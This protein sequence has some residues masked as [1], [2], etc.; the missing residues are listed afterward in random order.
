[1]I[2]KG[3]TGLTLGLIACA[4]AF[5][6]W[7]QGVLTGFEHAA[8]QWRVAHF[9]K[10]AA[11][12]S[13]LRIIALDQKSL[14][15]GR[16]ENNLSWP[17]PREAYA[18]LLAF[19]K[20][21]GVR[22]VAFDMLFSE[23]S[24]H[25]VGDDQALALAM[26]ENG[27]VVLSCTLAPPGQGQAENGSAPSVLTISGFSQWLAGSRA[28]VL[29]QAATMPV[30][31]LAESAAMLA[32]ISNRPDPDGV[33]RRA[34][35][36]VT[37]A[38]QPVPSLALAAYLAGLPGPVPLS[39]GK[40]H[41]QVGELG[42]PLDETGQSIL[43]FR[44]SSGTVTT[45]S[46]AAVVQSELQ[47][48]AGETPV[49]DPAE[50]KDTYVFLGMTAPGLYDL[51]AIPID[52]VYPGVE[53]HA[54][55]LDNLLSQD[56]LR[57]SPVWLAVFLTLLFGVLAAVIILFCGNAWQSS[58]AF[59]LLLPLPFVAGFIAYGKGFWLP[60]AVQAVAVLLALVSGVVFNFAT[61]GRKKRYIKRA[62]SQYL[63]PTVIDQLVANPERL[64][65][66]GEK[67]ELSIFFSDLAGFTGMSERLEPERLTLLLNEYLSAM[68]DIILASGGTIDKYE[69]DAIIAFWN[70]PLSQADHAGRAVQTALR[71]QER[72]AE[73]RPDF[74]ARF[75][76]DLFMRI[77]INTGPVVVGNLGSSQRFD[78]SILGDNA[79]VAARL[80]GVNKEFD[81]QILISESC[82]RQLPA[83]ITVREIARVG[84]MGRKEPITVFE[85]LAPGDTR[86][87]LRDRFAAALALYYQG[88]VAKAREAFQD[89]GAE[90]VVAG[91]Y[92]ARC[93]EMLAN[94]PLVW[95][96][97]WR[98]NSK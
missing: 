82:C 22:V 28:P 3:C 93:R 68:T 38:G 7:Q 87:T 35:L 80:E 95:D 63:H 92:A 4:M 69:G 64:R 54:T 25:G 55:M 52:G 90:D 89:M 48:A 42:V 12:T 29:P 65:L 2:K 33:F 8:W 70:A 17:W 79:N 84:V 97:V 15:W 98:M 60:V 21:A 27:P 76:C 57:D 45:I 86:R 83:G 58:L 77:G 81:T 23:S 49:I 75:G 41:L 94:P 59:V 46:L 16:K 73:L 30:A 5:F 67:R 71:C 72:L 51:R 44:G 40:K 10:P 36:F 50:F 24:L 13:R 43:N 1:M 61:E 85:P 32:N 47:L 14:D 37:L 91:R 56:F 39:L 53:I 74:K 34:P 31:E 78:Y 20:R 11:A 18:T 66:G 26:R 9:A 88:E 62:F 19:C 96:G 6:L